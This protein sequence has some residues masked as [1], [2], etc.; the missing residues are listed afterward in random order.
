MAGTGAESG[1][2]IPGRVLSPDELRWLIEE[3]AAMLGLSFDEAVARERKGTL[4][5]SPLGA[6]VAFLIRRMRGDAD[7]L[8][9]EETP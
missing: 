8:H 2:I 9:P 6:D 1:D 7:P 3:E 4:P 5:D